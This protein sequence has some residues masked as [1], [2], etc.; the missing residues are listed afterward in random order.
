M[1]QYSE[2]EEDSSDV[3]ELEDGVEDCDL[4]EN[5]MLYNDELY[6]VACNKF[7]NSASAKINH[8][9]SKKHRQNTELL[10]TE[11]KIEDENFK[12]TVESVHKN[13]DVETTIEEEEAGEVLEELETESVKG[14][15]KGKKSKKKNKKFFN[16]ESSDSE[17]NE[18]EEKEKIDI[19]VIETKPLQSDED[20]D[21]SENKKSKKTKSKGKSKGVKHKSPELEPIKLEEKTVEAPIAEEVHGTDQTGLCCV[22]CK[23]IFPSNN[24]LYI[25]LKKTNHSVYLGENKLK[26]SEKPSSRK[27]R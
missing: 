15:S 4:N 19:P 24:K 16:Y 18:K 7:F 22:T 9:A 21:W 3:T 11:M 23:Q 6:C 20:E 10:K 8:E 26:S 13:S 14:K 1:N 17:L 25:H 12:Q 2:N 27:K 5:E